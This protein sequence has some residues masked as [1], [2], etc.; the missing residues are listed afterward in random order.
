MNYNWNLIYI[1]LV[2]RMFIQEF[3]DCRLFQ[4]DDGSEYDE[5]VISSGWV[6]NEPDQVTIMLNAPVQ[7]NTDINQQ[8]II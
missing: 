2:G 3:F 1:S 4:D 6:Q 5:Y 7:V 8:Q